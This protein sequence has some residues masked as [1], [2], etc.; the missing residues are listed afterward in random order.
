MLAVGGYDYHPAYLK[1]APAAFGAMIGNSPAHNLTRDRVYV[2]VLQPTTEWDEDGKG[3]V[4]KL[5]RFGGLFIGRNSE[6]YHFV[7]YINTL[8]A[9]DNLWN[10]DTKDTAFPMQR[11]LADL[12]E[13]TILE[14][15]DKDLVGSDLI[16]PAIVRVYLVNTL[17]QLMAE[18]FIVPSVKLPM[19]FKVNT[20]TPNAANNGFDIDYS[21][22]LGKQRDYFRCTQNI[23]VG[24]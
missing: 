24:G 4:S 1:T 7:Q 20:V 14:G 12:V 21:T 23:I 6:G 10:V 5:L 16:T 11:D 3:Q 15:L 13:R 2:S 19:G 8:Q 22:S 18:N 17:K 9:N